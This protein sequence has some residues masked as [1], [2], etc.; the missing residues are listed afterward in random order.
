MCIRDSTYTKPNKELS[1]LKIMYCCKKGRHTHAL[2]ECEILKAVVSHKHHLFSDVVSFKQNLV[3]NHVL[4]ILLP[5]P[6]LYAG[7]PQ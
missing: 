3:A 1:N 7:H 6:C 5:T 4:S 2:E